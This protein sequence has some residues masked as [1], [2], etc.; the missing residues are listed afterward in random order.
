MK[1]SPETKKYKIIAAIL[2]TIVTVLFGFT[3]YQLV[4]PTPVSVPNTQTKQPIR[5]QPVPHNVPQ[6]ETTLFPGNRMV[7]IYGTPGVPAL[8]VLGEQSMEASIAR[9]KDLVTNYQG[10]SKEKIL[11]TMEIITTVAAGTPTENGDYSQEVDMQTLKPWVEAAQAAGVYIVLDL[12]PGRTDF[13]TQAKQYEDLLRYPNVGL[14]LDPEWRLA[15]NQVPLVQIGSVSIQEVNATANWLAEITRQQ[16][17]P[18]KLLLL[19]Q[20]RLSMIAD[21]EQLDTTH[22]ELAYVIQMDGQGAQNVKQDTWRT[23][24]AN[25]PA[26]VRFGWKNFYHQDSP[27]LSPEETMAL[28]PKPWYV[29]YQ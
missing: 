7:A 13:L 5:Q 12:Q 22:K 18:Q 20:F 19:H 25:A 15:P 16:K 1:L 24:T 14:A 28:D 4:K 8:G 26:N 17:L 27:V 6:K 10:F 11:P 3:I 29:S 9:A 23:I 2:M 21:R